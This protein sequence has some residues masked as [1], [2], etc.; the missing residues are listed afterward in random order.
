[1]E[2]EFKLDRTHILAAVL[3]ALVGSVLILVATRAI[4][5]IMSR[6]MENMMARM[7]SGEFEPPEM[8]REMMAKYCAD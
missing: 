1:M 6:M 8:C 3:G 7:E 5:K 4:P 2:R